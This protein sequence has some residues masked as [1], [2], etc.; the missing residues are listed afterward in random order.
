MPL[1]DIS[2]EEQ[3]NLFLSGVPYKDPVKL[4]NADRSKFNSSAG[5]VFQCG[6]TFSVNFGGK[7]PLTYYN[8]INEEISRRDD[9]GRDNY[10]LIPG[11]NQDVPN[12]NALNRPLA[13]PIKIKTS[14]S[15][16]D[17]VRDYGGWEGSEMGKM[18]F[19]H[20]TFQITEYYNHDGNIPIKK[21][22]YFLRGINEKNRIQYFVNV[23]WLSPPNL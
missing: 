9:G 17:Q 11:I 21:V 12:P 8:L 10:G 20:Q 4:T 7:L 23:A 16:T 6:L 18:V 19:R 13:W 22:I 3:S 5:S 2:K 14:V 15:T 1:K